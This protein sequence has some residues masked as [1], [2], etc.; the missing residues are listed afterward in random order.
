MTSLSLTVEERRIA[1]GIQ[2]R[3]AEL[4]SLMQTYDETAE[5]LV[6]LAR[7]LIA[8]G[9]HPGML[10]AYALTAEA[11]KTLTGFP[12]PVRLVKK[13]PKP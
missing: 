10:Y 2:P 9:D 4:R 11:Y 13:T 7:F 1:R 8:W 12:I 6:T 3:A 5:E